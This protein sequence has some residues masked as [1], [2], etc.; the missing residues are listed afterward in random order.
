MT[1]TYYED[2]FDRPLSKRF[3]EIEICLGCGKE[4]PCSSD[5]PAGSS[6]TAV[7]QRW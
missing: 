7:S 3:K 6:W 4:Q 1:T 2:K 5:C